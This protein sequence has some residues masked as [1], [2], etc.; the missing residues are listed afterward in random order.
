MPAPVDHLEERLRDAGDPLTEIMPAAI[1]LAMMLRQRTMAAWLRVEFEG[2]GE[3][4]ELPP[5]R[6]NIPGH[7][8]AQSPQ[9]GWIP[10]PVDAEQNSELGRLDL[11]EGVKVLEKT[12]LA[13]KKGSGRQIA[14]TPEHLAMLQGRINLKAKLAITISRSSYSD[15]VRT[16]RSVIYLWCQALIEEGVGGEHNSF[17]ADE[18]ASVAHLDDPA[19]FRDQAMAEAEA[20]NLP[21]PGVREAG[22][23]E[24]V[25]GSA[26]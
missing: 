25:F 18:R 7:I 1:T 15:L 12:C 5:Y 10:A 11:S 13:C 22:F 14:L 9:Y 20:G 26:G 21:V 8:V 24:R 4:A 16:I 3:D 23:F 6:H 17:T 2:Y 19:R